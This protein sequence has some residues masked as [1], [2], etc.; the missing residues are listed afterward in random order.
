MGEKRQVHFVD[1]EGVEVA[2]E[3]GA[4]QAGG[5][6]WIAVTDPARYRDVVA[7]YSVGRE[8]GTWHYAEEAKP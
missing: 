6:A 1:R 8:P 5:Y 2:A 4:L 7:C 3:L